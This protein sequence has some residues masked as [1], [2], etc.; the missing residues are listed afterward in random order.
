M[1]IDEYRQTVEKIVDRALSEGCQIG[2]TIDAGPDKDE[3]ILKPSSSRDEIVEHILSG[4][5]GAEINLFWDNTDTG[6]INF[7]WDSED[8]IAAYTNDLEDWLDDILN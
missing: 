5:A 2:V 6:Y 7:Q 1:V 8:I 4:V 3:I